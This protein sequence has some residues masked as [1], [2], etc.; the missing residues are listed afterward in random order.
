MRPL[1]LHLQNFLS[2]EDA[3]VDLHDLRGLVLLSGEHR[4]S[5]VAA[6]SNGAGKSALVDGLCW[7]LYGRMARPRHRAE[8][9]VRRDAAGDCC[10]TLTFLDGAG[11]Q[12]EVARHRK[13]S[14]WKDALL[15]S[16]DGTDARGSSATETQR[17]LD[18]IVGLDFDTFVG[19]VLF[20][21][22]PLRGRFAELGDEQKK[23]LLESILGVEVL[24]HA[25]E[26]VKDQARA[27]E[28]DL[29]KAEQRLQGLRDQVSWLERQ[30]TDYRTRALDW[31]RQHE[32]RGAAL[33]DKV[34]ALRV[35]VAAQGTRSP[36]R[37][38]DSPTADAS[39]LPAATRA[40][41]RAEAAASARDGEHER[42][43]AR[44]Q[45]R[46]ESARTLL[47]RLQ[48]ELT[49]LRTQGDTCPV[50]AQ[51]IRPEARE[52]HAGEIEAE[53]S[54]HARVVLDTR[55]ELTKLKQDRESARVAWT[56]ERRRQEAG[57]AELRSRAEGA[58]AAA[59]A[60]AAWFREHELLERQLHEAEQ[61]LAAHARESNTFTGLLEKA[62]GDLLARHDAFAST[63]SELG[64]LRSEVEQLRFW[65]HG[66]GPRGLRSYVLDSV[67]PLLNQRSRFYADLLT[68]GALT[69]HF[70]T[71]VEKDGALEDRFTVG[72]VH[73]SGVD[74]Y[75]LLSGGERQRVNLIINLALQDLV[76]SRATRPLPIAIYDEAFEG[77]DRTGVEAAVRVLSE[78]ARDKELVLVV[79]HQD[80]LKDLFAH[81]LRVVCDR[82]RSTVVTVS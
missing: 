77:L 51:P 18:Q 7:A 72:V 79:T 53:M 54:D 2:F 29:E 60:R 73:R 80:A 68:A 76:G 40:L 81:E 59:A 64:K 67:V 3:E 17:R 66:F 39:A 19:S 21:Q 13:H 5:D 38:D 55:A 78:A 31:D 57:L 15:L 56:G 71:T 9:V 52:A 14:K 47:G 62:E 41:E 48:A 16:I 58:R 36:A 63:D 74:S 4:G 22:H 26:L 49:K 8:D 10:V 65:D 45:A 82:G 34:A 28:K 32:A 44:A 20:T 24:A 50:C 37:A 30:C 69:V 61:Q 33:A 75:A 43:A 12:I 1:Y 70:S 11:R 42:A 6:D 23:E 27:K 25:R 46:Q 35:D